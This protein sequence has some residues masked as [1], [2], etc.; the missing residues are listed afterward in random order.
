[1]PLWVQKEIEACPG[2]LERREAGQCGAVAESRV[3]GGLA[4]GE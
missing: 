1:M 2:G 4:V 3:P